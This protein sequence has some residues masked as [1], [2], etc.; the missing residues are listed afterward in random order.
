MERIKVYSIDD[1]VMG[2]GGAV[3]KLQEDDKNGVVTRTKPNLK[4]TSHGKA[5]LQQAVGGK[6][7]GS[8]VFP[9]ATFQRLVLID[10]TRSQNG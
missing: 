4:K 8:A 7:G 1:R 9:E 6:V 2:R 10:H 5:Y 3:E